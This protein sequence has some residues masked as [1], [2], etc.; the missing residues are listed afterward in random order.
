MPFLI[1]FAPLIACFA[2]LPY[3]TKEQ[4][5]V[6]QANELC[7]K[8]FQNTKDINACKDILLKR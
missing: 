5:R 2:A 8:K 1:L 6:K 3:E 7:I 4:E